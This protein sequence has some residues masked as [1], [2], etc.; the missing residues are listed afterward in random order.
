MFT[1]F[2][3]WTG[4]HWWGVSYDE[5]HANSIPSSLS[6][7]DEHHLVISANESPSLCDDLSSEY[8]TVKASGGG[9]K[10]LCVIQNLVSVF[11]LSKPSCYKWDTCSPH[12][13]LLS[14][15][16]GVLDLHRALDIMNENRGLTIDGLCATLKRDAQ[17]KYNH[18][19]LVNHHPGQKW[20][21]SGGLLAYRNIGTAVRLLQR[22]ARAWT[23]PARVSHLHLATPFTYA[24]RN[25]E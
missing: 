14:L 5:V 21:N 11:L 4:T 16:G 19:D 17:L 9:Y 18:P 20:C 25:L 22:L 12:A 8:V 6:N 2:I 13:I 24:F 23:W 10:L 7:T 3:S 15:G 1:F